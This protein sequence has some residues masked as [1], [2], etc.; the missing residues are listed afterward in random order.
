MLSTCSIYLA[1]SWAS[2]GTCL[3]IFSIEGGVLNYTIG[4]P[5]KYKSKVPPE[6]N[7]DKIS[8]G[9]VRHQYFLKWILRAW[10]EFKSRSLTLFHPWKRLVWGNGM[11]HQL[12]Y[13]ILAFKALCYS[14]LASISILPSYSYLK[15]SWPLNNTV[16]NFTG[17]TFPFDKY[18]MGPIR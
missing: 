11:F 10:M 2:A 5:G 6:T 9:G 15:Y 13:F 8:G 16:L 4:T 14:D 7:F 12:E 3:A 18:I 17:S 1:L